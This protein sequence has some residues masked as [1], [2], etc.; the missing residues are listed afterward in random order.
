MKFKK[1]NLWLESRTT[2]VVYHVTYYR[3]LDSIADSGLDHS[4]IFYRKI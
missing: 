4:S 2:P 1:F 3:N